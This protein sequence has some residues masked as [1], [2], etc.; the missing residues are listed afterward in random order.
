MRK[1]G[2]LWA[3]SLLLSSLGWAQ[4]G[5]D[6]VCEIN[7]SVP[8]PG[9]AK[10]FEEARKKHNEFHKAE[11]DKNMIAVWQTTTGPF[12]GSY[13]VRLWTGLEGSGWSRRV[14]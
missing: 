12:T 5:P 7:V 6:S 9:G 11:K 3:A 1:L 10:Q 13:D 2:M 4:S 8:K 14:R